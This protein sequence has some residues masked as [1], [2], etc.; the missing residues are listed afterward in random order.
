[1]GWETI[2]GV[3]LAGGGWL[4][5]GLIALRFSGVKR[6]RDEADIARNEQAK[7]LKE[8]TEAFI[9]YRKRQSA[10][11]EDLEDE[12]AEYQERLDECA[13]PGDHRDRLNRLLQKTRDASRDAQ[14]GLSGKEPA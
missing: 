4:A 10:R 3:A 12:I 8:A 2:I 9:E 11:L 7:E 5:F 14:D 13:G 1:M 6:D